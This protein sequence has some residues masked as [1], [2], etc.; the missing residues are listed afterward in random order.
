MNFLTAFINI[1]SASGEQQMFFKPE[2]FVG[3]LGHMGIG[4]LV[5]FILIGVIILT[6]ALINKIFSSKK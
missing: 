5:I 2:L 6:T 4:M 1:L 3:K